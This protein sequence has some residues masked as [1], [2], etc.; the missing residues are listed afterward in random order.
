M[1]IFVSVDKIRFFMSIR[2]VDLLVLCSSCLISSL[3]S[4]PVMNF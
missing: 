1:V 3:F 4:L 2:S